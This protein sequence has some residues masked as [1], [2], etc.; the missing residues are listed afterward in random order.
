[1]VFMTKGQDFILFNFII[2][3]FLL[4]LNC[5]QWSFCCILLSSCVFAILFICIHCAALV[6][7]KSS[8]GRL[9][10]CSFAKMVDSI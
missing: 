3:L 8:Y 6:N 9:L 1:M 10:Q 2:L 7:K 4:T 5:N